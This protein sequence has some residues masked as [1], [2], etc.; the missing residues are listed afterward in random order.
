MRGGTYSY[1][2]TI[3]IAPGNDGTS[4]ALKTLSAYPGETPVLNFSA[5]AEDRRQPRRWP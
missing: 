3:T 2:S 1:S 5:M 4:S